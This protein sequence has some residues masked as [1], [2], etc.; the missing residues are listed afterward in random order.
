MAFQIALLA[1]LLFGA[2]DISRGLAAPMMQSDWNITYWQLGIAFSANSFGYVVSSFA[3]GMILHRVGLRRAIVTGA[4]LSAAGLLGL[5]WRHEFALVVLGFLVY[6]VGSGVL[7]IGING[8]VPA[9]AGDTP[10]TSLFNLL[11]GLYGAGAFGFPVVAVWLMGRLHG[12]RPLYA[13]LAM[14]LLCVW[15]LGTLTK[16]PVLRR[17][18]TDAVERA[19]DGAAPRARRAGSLYRS[20]LLYVLLVAITA[21]VMAEAAVCGWLPTYLVH[22]RNVSLDSSSLCLSGFYLTF[23]AGRLTAPLWVQRAGRYRALLFSVCLALVAFCCALWVGWP[24]PLFIAAGAGFA[25]VFPTIAAVASDMFRAE[26]GVVIGVLY[27]AAGFGSMMLNALI[28]WLSSRFGI[29][30][31]FSTTALF[32]CVVL[33]CTWLAQKVAPPHREAAAPMVS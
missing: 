21:Y 14:G 22:A 7:E 27:T 33:A 1:M 3:S 6:G 25:I 10:S 17:T 29:G 18:A 20:P 26:A 2:I 9:L 11:H 31:G 8:V 5:A 12:W 23:T 13:L 24:I 19:P 15:L 4:L 16:H 30:V 28:G 32:L